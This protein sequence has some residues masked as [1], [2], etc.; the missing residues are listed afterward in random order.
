MRETVNGFTKSALIEGER[1]DLLSDAILILMTDFKLPT[2]GGV[3]VDICVD[4]APGFQKL[5]QDPL[6]QQYGINF[7]IGRIKTLTKI[8][9]LNG[10]F[11]N[12]VSN[13]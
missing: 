2:D 11:K 4:A 8:L 3:A 1:H 5:V 10:Q 13:V 9:L 7:V 6:L 12:L